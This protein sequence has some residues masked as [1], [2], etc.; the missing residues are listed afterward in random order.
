MLCASLFII[1]FE[2]MWNVILPSLCQSLSEKQKQKQKKQNQQLIWIDI[3]QIRFV[4][5]I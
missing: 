5:H 3:K 1:V 4:K 2:S